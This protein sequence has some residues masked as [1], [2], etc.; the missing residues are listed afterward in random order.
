MA[1]QESA[2]RE[3]SSLKQRVQAIEGAL[4]AIQSGSLQ[5]NDAFQGLRLEVSRLREDLQIASRRDSQRGSSQRFKIP[6][7]SKFEHADGTRTLKAW[8]AQF[9]AYVDYTSPV[10]TESLM[11]SYLGGACLQAYL[12]HQATCKSEDRVHDL[13]SFERVLQQLTNLGNQQEVARQQ[14]KL[15]RQGT[16]TI[17]AYNTAFAALAVEC[18]DRSDFDKVG[19]YVDGL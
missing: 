19:D 15:L 4:A 12:V 11:Q 13:D 9:R 7:P 3:V 17:A 16:M 14:M 6:A 2:S 8:M 18:P 5:L 1:D 10:L